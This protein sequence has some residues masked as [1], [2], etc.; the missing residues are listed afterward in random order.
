MLVRVKVIT[1]MKVKLSVT[2]R[3]RLHSV[4]DVLGLFLFVLFELSLVDSIEIFT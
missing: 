4:V 3:V 1:K 2:S